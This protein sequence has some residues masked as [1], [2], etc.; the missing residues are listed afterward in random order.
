MTNKETP[1]NTQTKQANTHNREEYMKEERSKP[2][3]RQ[4]SNTHQ[5]AKPNQTKPKESRG[6]ITNKETLT[7]TKQNNAKKT[8][9]NKNTRKQ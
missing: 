2:P 5:Q 4:I 6:N 9:T 8:K 3:N 1:L 7:T